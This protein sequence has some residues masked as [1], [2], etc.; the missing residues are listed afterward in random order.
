MAAVKMSEPSRRGFL[1][2]VSAAAI[3]PLAIHITDV[4]PGRS[5]PLRDLDLGPGVITVADKRGHVFTEQSVMTAPGY[6][7]YRIKVE[8]RTD[9]ESRYYQRVFV[10]GATI[11]LTATSRG[12]MKTVAKPIEPQFAYG[13]H[14][15]D[16]ITYEWPVEILP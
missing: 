15:G 8:I 1:G 10:E 14:V 7:V 12:L 16:T 2:L 13:L 5:G 3:A 4:T 9:E 6:N 11:A